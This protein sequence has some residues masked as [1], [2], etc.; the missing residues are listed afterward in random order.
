VPV[1]DLHSTLHLDMLHR[2]KRRSLLSR[3][4]EA[5]RTSARTPDLYGL[6]WGD[7]DYVEPLRFIRD[8][9]VLPYVNPKQTALEIGPGGGRWT[10]Y[11]LR[12][13]KLYVVDYYQELLDEL[14]KHFDAPNMIFVKNSG[15][16]FPGVAPASVDYVFSFGAFVHLEVDLIASYLRSLAPILT[17]SA[18]VVVQYSDKT[19]VMAR[20]NA[21][22][23]EN[24]PETMRKMVVAAGYEILE[25][26]LTTLWHSSVV[27]FRRAARQGGTGTI[28]CD[29]PAQT[30]GAGC[31]EAAS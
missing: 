25:E 19:K 18:N 26:D 8:R 24:T 15:T 16:D 20:E 11:L 6:H 23:S 28:Q 2:F 27:R 21:G 22:F 29:G 1:P 10:R 12:F 7:P 14:K 13:D 5:V 9:Y 4:F 17:T 3:V 31:G 30:T